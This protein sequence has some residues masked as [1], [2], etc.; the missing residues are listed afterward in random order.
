VLRHNLRL[1]GAID[2]MYGGDESYIWVS[3]KD[4][5][6]EIKKKMY[7]TTLFTKSEL[8]LKIS[9]C[10]VRWSICVSATVNGWFVNCAQ[11]GT[12]CIPKD[13]TLTLTFDIPKLHYLYATG[14]Y[15]TFP[16]IVIPFLQSYLTQY[17]GL[18]K[19]VCREENLRHRSN[20]L[21]IKRPALFWRKKS[22]TLF[23]FS[24]NLA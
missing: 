1:G 17:M 18:L 8:V 23:T 22:G 9:L 11:K 21:K 20:W 24:A 6:K 4:D 19:G 10:D 12:Q 13:G 5:R 16:F 3:Y 14:T 2:E 7:F 15:F